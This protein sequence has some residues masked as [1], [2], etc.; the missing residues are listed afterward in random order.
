MPTH[1]PV[2]IALIDD[3]SIFQ[4]TASRMLHAADNQATVLQF[5]NGEEG[6]RYLLMNAENRANLPDIIL[7]DINMPYMDG[8][9][10]L[11]DYGEL[12]KQL[13]KN[14]IIY[15]VSSSID[16]VDINRA[17]SNSNVKDFLIKPIL[18]EGFRKLLQASADTSAN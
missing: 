15:M 10:F 9:T 14:I 16:P 5:S 13:Q 8:W 7:L 6:L 3:D 4:L 1:N 2:T 12:K 18:S 17:K 11:N